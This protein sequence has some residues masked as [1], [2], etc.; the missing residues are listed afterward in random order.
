MENIVTRILLV[1]DD[2]D[3]HFIFKDI[4]RHVNPGI[5]L[6]CFSNPTE[7]EN[8]AQFSLPHF[9]FL[10]INMPSWNGFEWLKWISEG[11]Y[12][13]PVIMYSTSI[14]PEYIAKAY[15]EGAHLYLNKP[16]DFNE[17]ILSVRF[18]LQLDW[19]DPEKIRQ[20]CKIDG[21]YRAISYRDYEYFRQ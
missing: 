3:E 15:S 12:R 10:D 13:F 19:S 1:D 8:S 17:L 20:Q 21:V 18:I 2:E 11:G 9:L 7:L 14:N 4:I 6:N 5:Q 16:M